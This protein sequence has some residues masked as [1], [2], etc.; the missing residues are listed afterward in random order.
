[1]STLLR[2]LELLQIAPPSI[3]YD[4]Q[5]QASSSAIDQQCYEIIDDTGQVIFIPSIMD[6]TDPTLVDILAWQFHVD[7]YDFTRDLEFRKKLVQMSIQWHKTKGTKALVE[8]VIDTYWPGSAYLQEWFE[9]PSWGQAQATFD[10]SKVDVGNDWFLSPHTPVQNGDQLWFVAGIV[11]PPASP[12]TSVL[13]QPIDPTLF[14]YTV[15][16]SGSHVQLSLTLGGPP[17]NLTDAGTG[18]NTVFKKVPGTGFPPNYPQPGWHDRYRFRIV[19]NEDVLVDPDE[20][21]QVLKLIDRYKPISRWP[22][23]VLHPHTGNLK[24]IFCAGAAQFII[25]RQSKMAE[26]APTPP[27]P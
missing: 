7:F 27:I 11:P 4:E 1:M 24:E 9:Y 25:R 23:G 13:P 16:A 3:A 15:N 6:L 26:Q 8:E 5:V 19:L 18:T 17:I 22:D 14:Y 20:Q 10:P 21:A 12:D 2:D